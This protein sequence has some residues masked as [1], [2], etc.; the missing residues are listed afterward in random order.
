MSRAGHTD[1]VSLVS[2]VLQWVP[3]AVWSSVHCLQ[4]LLNAAALGSTWRES[5]VGDTVPCGAEPQGEGRC[6]LGPQIDTESSEMLG[7]DMG[8]LGW[9]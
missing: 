8:R 3:P 7:R 9:A 2:C 6:V 1:H 5:R 4:P